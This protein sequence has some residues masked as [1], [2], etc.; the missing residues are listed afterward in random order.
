MQT[1]LINGLLYS[2]SRARMQIQLL[3]IKQKMVNALLFR[4]IELY[5]GEFLW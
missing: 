4:A 5:D 3:S 2:T 1:G